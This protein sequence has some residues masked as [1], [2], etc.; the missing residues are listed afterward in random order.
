[1]ST[2]LRTEPSNEA[3]DPP[4]EA[5][6]GVLGRFAQMRFEFAEGKF[7]WIKVGRI[8]REVD[9][10]SARRSIAAATP[11]TLCTGRLSMST[12]SPRFSVGT[13]HCCT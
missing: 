3:P 6:N 13:R 2:L 4:Q 9:Q 1:V 11:M 7:D 10:R 5:W 12:I 8:L